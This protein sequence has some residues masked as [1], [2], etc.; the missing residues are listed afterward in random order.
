M[1]QQPPRTASASAVCSRRIFAAFA[2]FAAALHPAA[3]NARAENCRIAFDM[4]SS[5]IRAGASNSAQT[6]RRDLDALTPLW[7]GKGVGA[8][9]P[10]VSAALRELPREAGLADEC[11]RVGGG[12][13]AWRL[14]LAQDGASLADALRRIRRDSG[15][16][17]LV[18]PLRQ[19]G[20]YGYFAAKQNLG[21]RFTSTHALDLGGGSLQ[22]AG[23]HH[24]FATALGQKAWHRELCR[25]LRNSDETPCALQPMSEADLAHAR[26]LAA[27]HLKGLQSAL[28]GTTHMTAISRPVTR[29][30]APAVQQVTGGE[31]RALRRIAVSATIFRLAPL[32]LDET[33][34][35]TGAQK[36]HTHYLISDLLLVESLMRLTGDADLQIAESE[37]TNVPGLLADDRVY[38]WAAHHDC[39]LDRLRRIGVKAFDSDPRSCDR[40]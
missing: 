35:V 24:S 9:E 10:S 11:T 23:A 40:R 27:H 6:A 3:G 29:G 7:A 8:I 39:Y 17:V 38:A 4:G 28:P 1:T 13:S 16:A 37:A 25:T 18:I 32:S 5:G 26:R 31:P 33:A 2:L 14:A 21:E 30:V 20:A 36:K 34:T 22:I 15:V 19:E 12:F